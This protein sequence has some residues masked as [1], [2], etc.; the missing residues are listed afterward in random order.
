MIT[1]LVEYGSVQS[2]EPLTEYAKLPS[3][4]FSIAYKRL[5]A[6]LH[7]ISIDSSK[8]YQ[9]RSRYQEVEARCYS[10]FLWRVYARTE[11]AQREHNGCGM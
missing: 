5:H 2:R 1:D 8:R 10:R 9:D 3:Y 7:D 11:M 6:A 4:Y